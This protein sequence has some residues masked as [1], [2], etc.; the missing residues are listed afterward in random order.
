MESFNDVNNVLWIPFSAFGCDRSPSR[1]T[2]ANVTVNIISF[3]RVTVGST[4]AIPFQLDQRVSKASV[5]NVSPCLSCGAC[6]SFFRVS[7]YWGEAES[8]GGQVPDIL[9]AKVN[10]FY[11]CMQGTDRQQSRCVALL[12][13]V[14]SQVRCSIYQNRSSTCRE[15]E[16]HSETLAGNPD[17]N[18]ARAHHGLAALPDLI[19]ERL[20]PV[21]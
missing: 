11:S 21:G 5:S 10:D 1:I 13:E 20:D 18:R 3:S 4:I 6:C 19:P 7:F 15:F 9:T 8:A 17:C 14:G 16:C 2:T 12:G